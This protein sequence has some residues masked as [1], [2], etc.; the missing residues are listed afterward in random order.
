MSI[1]TYTGI[2]ACIYMDL[3]KAVTRLLAQGTV[4][5]LYRAPD[6]QKSEHCQQ[7][8]RIPFHRVFLFLFLA[9]SKHSKTSTTQTNL[10][11]R[12]QIN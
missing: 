5:S 2:Y 1:Y 11:K 9:G 7:I 6:V 12:S 3:S 8:T 4:W 10:Y